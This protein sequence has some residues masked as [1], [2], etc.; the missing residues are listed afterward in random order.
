MS[1]YERPFM[2]R[3]W[4]FTKDISVKVSRKAEKYW[5]IN[6]L[7]VEIA[8]IKHRI[9][10]KYKELG[11]YVY[12][13]LKSGS[14][15]ETAYK[16]SLQEFYDEISHLENEI[17]EREHRIETLERQLAED[18]EPPPPPVEEDEEE[19]LAREID[20]AT[21]HEPAKADEQ[22]SDVDLDSADPAE[23]ESTKAMADATKKAAS[24]KQGE[25]TS[26]TAEAAQAG[27]QDVAKG[28]KKT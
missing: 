20:K 2:D 17:I 24:A 9:S 12:E 28:D 4:E 19:R 21:S 25:E 8:S 11:R 1:D 26:T 22:Q 10:V 15:E 23:E 14:P 3:V 16:S 18:Q 5:K 6:T 13:S 27:G 7:R